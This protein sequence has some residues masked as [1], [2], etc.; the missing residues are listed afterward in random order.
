[1]FGG[2]SIFG[3]KRPSS[4][5]EKLNATTSVFYGRKIGIHP[6]QESLFTN[7]SI[8]P[9]SQRFGKYSKNQSENVS[10]MSA[11]AHTDAPETTRQST[12]NRSCNDDLHAVQ[13]AN[14]RPHRENELDPRR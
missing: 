10:Q 9:Y 3:Q 4:P 11:K 5:G 1:M 8:R 14:I 2:E 12:L 6:R 7:R 13:V